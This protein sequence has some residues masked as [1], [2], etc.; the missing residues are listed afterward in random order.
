M[1]VHN[2]RDL[3]VARWT[4]GT[5]TQ[6][7]LFPP[8]ASFQ[9]R[10]FLFR[11]S[12]AVIEGETSDFTPL[13]GF[14]RILIVLKGNMV[15]KH[16]FE[17]GTQQFALGTFEQHSFKGE[18]TTTS[19]GSITDFNVIFKPEVH[20]EAQVLHNTKLTVPAGCFLFLWSIEGETSVNGISLRES[21][22]VFEQL[23][24]SATLSVKGRACCVI[25]RIQE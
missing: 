2:S 15:L 13:A 9:E 4:G 1:K 22:F 11:I 20:A 12:T 3:P 5:T 7:V 17:H 10:N 24:E 23:K 25:L 16:H 21:H 14:E 8:D 19:E 18:W 6:L